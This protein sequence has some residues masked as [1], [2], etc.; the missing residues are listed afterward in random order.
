[1]PKRS[2]ASTRRRERGHQNASAE[3]RKKPGAVAAIAVLEDPDRWLDLRRAADLV[4]VGEVEIH[5]GRRAVPLRA[6]SLLPVG[7]AESARK[8][9]S[10]PTCGTG[11]GEGPE[12]EAARF[13]RAGRIAID[14][15]ADQAH[16]GFP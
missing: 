2:A 6:C 10:G 4:Q 9:D 16:A 13:D 3:R 15:S 7:R 12:A 11:T 8:G 1:M 5:R 14:E